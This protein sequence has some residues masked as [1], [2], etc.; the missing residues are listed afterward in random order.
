[1]TDNNRDD[2]ALGDLSRIDV[3][4]SDG[5]RRRPAVAVADPGAPSR[6][7]PSP[8]AGATGLLP[9]KQVVLVALVAALLLVCG[10][11]LVQ[12]QRLASSL[13]VLEARA[14]DS[15]LSLETQVAST[16]TSLKS[17]DSQ[18]QQSLDVLAADIGKVNGAVGRLSRLVDKQ[19][20]D[21]VAGSSELAALAAEVRALAE[22]SAQS[23]GQLEVRLE[24]RLKAVASLLEQQAARQKALGEAVTR[25]ERTGDLAQLRSEVAV[26]G[27]SLRDIQDEH[28][29][30]LRAAEQ[31]IA[32]NDAFR[33][34]VNA[35]IDRLV[36]QVGELSAR[37]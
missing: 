16:A 6:P 24:A 31:A 11:L 34:Q 17:N 5:P 33:R 9:K 23:T 26:L 4:G 15:V 37:R 29:K 12:Q 27:A 1:M 25:L 20:K 30:R 14:Q 3:T 18:T 7:S 8:L 28:G 21:L 32:S 10:W 13:A 19:G 36:Q 22:T 2:V 35:S